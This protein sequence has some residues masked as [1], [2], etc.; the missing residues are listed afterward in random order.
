MDAYRQQHTQP[1][2]DWYDALD[3]FNRRN[4]LSPQEKRAFERIWRWAGGREGYLRGFSV[5]ELATALGCDRRCASDYFRALCEGE[6]RV[7]TKMRAGAWLIDI[8]D[9][10]GHTGIMQLYVYDP[11]SELPRRRD[12]DPQ[13]TLPGFDDSAGDLAQDPPSPPTL[14]LMSAGD[15]AQ[16]PPSA[17]QPGERTTGVPAQNPPSN[18]AARARDTYTSSEFNTSLDKP[19]PTPNRNLPDEGWEEVEEVLRSTGMGAWSIAMEDARRRKLPPRE[20]LDL[21]DHWQQHAPAWDAGALFWRIKNHSP[22]QPI[23]VGWAKPAERF[24]RAKSIAESQRQTAAQQATYARQRLKADAD[25]AELRRLEAKYGGHLDA[26][27]REQ[28]EAIARSCLPAM[29]QA[30]FHTDGCARAGL[31]REA[32][33]THLAR[34]Q[35]VTSDGGEEPG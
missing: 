19:P 26:L 35:L 20:I 12:P 31:V 4:D 16:D 27:P 21:V 2:F 10:G 28:L 33:L 14:K 8:I 25:A 30:K 18:V 3:E 6:F 13:R 23:A 15:S 5:S 17:P 29:L 34:Q 11:R 7:K 9:D 22:G 32:L 24:T 1:A